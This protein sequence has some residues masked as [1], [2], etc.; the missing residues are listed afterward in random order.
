MNEF[1]F[2]S[3]LIICIIDAQP[4]ESEQMTYTVVDNALNDA[5]KILVDLQTYKGASAEIRQ[6]CNPIFI[7][8]LFFFLRMQ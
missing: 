4:T 5:A 1:F 8:I 6:V 2:F 7:I 3:N